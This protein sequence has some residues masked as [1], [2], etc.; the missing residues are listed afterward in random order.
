MRLATA[1]FEVT[2]LTPV[3]ILAAAAIEQ[4]AYTPSPPAK[5]YLQELQNRS[6]TY[7]GLRV[8]RPGGEESQLVGVA[9]SWLL[10]GALHV[11]TLAIDPAWQQLGLGKWL[12]QA[13]LAAGLE[14][15]A[16]T[17]TLEVRPSNGAAR[18]V[19]DQSGFKEVG[20]RRAYYADGEDALILTLPEIN[21]P[22]VQPCL[23]SQNS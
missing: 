3:D 13:L 7:L 12:L 21:L 10:A 23:K 6:A 16:K 20:R 22:P 1:I 11:M 9:G 8:S 17:A 2:P 18:A 19:Y 15:G 4:A 5:D 14:Q